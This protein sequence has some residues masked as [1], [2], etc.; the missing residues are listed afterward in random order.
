MDV[1]FSPKT[2][3]NS[4]VLAATIPPSACSADTSLYTREAL[5]RCITERQFEFDEVIL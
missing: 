2:N 1:A 5:V 3:A 4:L